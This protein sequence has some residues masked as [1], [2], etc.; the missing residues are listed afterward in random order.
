MSHRNPQRIHL[1]SETCRWKEPV[2]I[3]RSSFNGTCYLEHILSAPR[4]NE[5]DPLVISDFLIH[6]LPWSPPTISFLF[7]LSLRTPDVASSLANRPLLNRCYKSSCNIVSKLPAYQQASPVVLGGS[8]SPVC[9]CILGRASIQDDKRAFTYQTFRV[10]MSVFR[11][12]FFSLYYWRLWRSL[13]ALWVCWF[14]TLFL[15]CRSATP[16]SLLQLYRFRGI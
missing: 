15:I 16:S 7:F 2:L 4:L 10:K 12:M 11:L 8:V 1:K 9:L 14:P 6:I 3:R 13:R 5:N